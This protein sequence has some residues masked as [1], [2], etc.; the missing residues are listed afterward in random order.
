MLGSFVVGVAREQS[1]RAQ[2]DHGHM[3]SSRTGT[4]LPFCAVR[5]MTRGAREVVKTESKGKGNK[6]LRVRIHDS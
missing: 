4:E 6:R 1:H 3:W 2:P 5:S